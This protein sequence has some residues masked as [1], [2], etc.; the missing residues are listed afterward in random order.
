MDLHGSPPPSAMTIRP[1]DL[2]IDTSS[3]LGNRS[4]SVFQANWNNQVVAVKV[5]SLSSEISPEVSKPLI[6]ILNLI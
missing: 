4:G 6:L 2:A 3:P 1:E 5:L